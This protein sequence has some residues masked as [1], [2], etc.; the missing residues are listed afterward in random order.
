MRETEQPHQSVE[1][2]VLLISCLRG[3]PFV[4]PHDMN[5]QTLLELAS[6]H[7]VLL[8]VYQTFMERKVE[9]PGF[10]AAA[11]Q[12]RRNA[13]EMF[14][15]ELEGLLKQF[16]ERGIEVLPLKGPVLAEALYGDA[17]IR[18][19]S[20]LDLLVRREDFRHA[21]VLLLEMGFVVRPGDEK[22][23]RRFLRKGV[24]VELHFGFG[25]SPFF[26]V[27]SLPF[28]ANAVWARAG[29][30]S[31]RGLPIRVMSDDDLVLFLCLHGLQHGFSRLIW[32]M[33]IARGLATI[34]HR[35]AAQ[36]A[37]N[38]RQQGLELALL[39]GCEMVRETFPQQLPQWIDGIVAESPEMAA[40]VRHA[41]SG[42]FAE[43]AE[44]GSDREV[45]MWSFYLQTEGD[46]HRRWK[47]RLSFFAPTAE[48]YAWAD[49]NRIYPSLA[50]VLRPF[51]L[52]RKYGPAR[53][54]R[55]LF[56]PRG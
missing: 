12:E 53:V 33:D 1:E 39:I 21:E 55:T 26:P 45:E 51:R 19:Y 41:V 6:A 9:M 16:A 56:P 52:L 15:A 50:P 42:L 35:S 46:P 13:A 36:L 23:H 24:M 37:R 3:T 29:I 25:S 49:R 47:R 40:R 32:I 11:V 8:L 4:V 44:K 43:G 7:G 10:F 54:W 38:A 34:R 5:W 31:F 20:D 48:D 18:S 28:D 2:A 30:E 22:Y 14:A 17:T 27:G